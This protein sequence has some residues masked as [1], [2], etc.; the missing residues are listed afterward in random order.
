[1]EDSE[2]LLKYLKQGIDTLLEQG[3]F[4]GGQEFRP[5]QKQALE[6]YQ[7]Y[8]NNEQYTPEDRLKG[9]F[10]I[11]TGVG[12]TAIFVGIISAAHKVAEQSGDKLK[13]IIVVP[14]TQLLDQTVEAI[15]KFSPQLQNSIGLYGDG[16][17]NLELPITVMTYD[18]FVELT[19]T[20]Q[21]GSHNIDIVI[22]DEAHRGTSERRVKSI[23]SSFNSNTVQ[24]AVTATAHFDDDKSV[25]N[26]H[27]R[28]IFYKSVADAIKEGE[29]AAYVSS[30]RYVI[31]VDP[32]EFMLSDKFEEAS[33]VRKRA[34]RQA[35]K[36]NAW[37]K[38][39]VTIFRDGRDEKTGDLLSDNQAGFFVE[40]TKQADRIEDLLNNDSEL[41]SRAHKTGYKGVAVAIHSNLPKKEQKR[42]YKAYKNGEYLAVVGDEMFKEGFDHSPMKT[43]F[44]CPH[45]SIVDKAQ[46]LGRGLRK[47]WNDLKERFEGVTII[48]TVI[49]LSD[50]D[51]DIEERNRGRALVNTVS[52]KQVL[53]GSFIGSDDY[54]KDLEK[55]P[56]SKRKAYKAK[57]LF[58]DDPDVDEYTSLEELY[59][60]EEEVSILRR[61]Y[62]I[63]FSAD[64]RK[65]F[66]SHEKR[67]GL[68]GEA[69]FN[70]IV[71]PPEGLDGS[72]AHNIVKGKNKSVDSSYV[73]AL[74]DTYRKQPDTV[75]VPISKIDADKILEA[76]E[77]QPDNTIEP[78]LEDDADKMTAETERTGLTGKTLFSRISNP[79]KGLTKSVTDN[80]VAG[81]TKSAKIEFIKTI[82][83]TY[84]KQLDNNITMV[85]ISE[86]DI[87]RMEKEAKRTVK[88][89]LEAYE[90]Q[91]DNTIEPISEDDAKKIA[92]EAERTGL[93]GKVLLSRMSN[94]Y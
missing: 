87:S 90:Q 14:T 92:E 73:T 9:F 7:R 26:S 54:F 77:Q 84:R 23:T 42:R 1:M 12:K 8:L 34:Y 41:T 48:D 79:P 24:L 63:F 71:N 19:E 13:T 21:I 75:M 32:D 60:L 51:P 74:L 17:K 11:P 57:S 27:L 45:S 37:N 10:E 62:R 49:Y 44:D 16:K 28:E 35:A 56:S 82:L 67:T 88:A 6:A 18:A 80:I 31:R 76:Y 59:A 93:S 85:G 22:S 86:N 64:L 68:G 81:V 29:L 91:P 70:R 65:E 20:N 15:E 66:Q 2:K 69:I 89:I 83:D 72:I 36:Q 33:D 52:V 94:P 40:S 3:S 47:W 46:I 50:D 53:E 39:M 43:I 38:R 4:D 58:D 78:I 5:T 30:Q 55:T 25:E 61:E